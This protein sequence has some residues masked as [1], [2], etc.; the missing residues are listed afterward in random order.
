[1]QHAAVVLKEYL[2][3]RGHQFA[4]VTPELHRIPPNS[5][6]VI[7]KVDEGPKVKV[8]EINPDRQ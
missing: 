3:E 2:A 7:F 4:T 6:E 8:G 5:L 1:M